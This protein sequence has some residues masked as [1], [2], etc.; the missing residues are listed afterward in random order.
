MSGT[1]QDHR[2]S[3][4]QAADPD[5]SQIHATVRMLNLAVAQIS[6]ALRDGEDSC[7]ALAGHFTAAVAGVARIGELAAGNVPDSREQGEIVAAC[8]D[9]QQRMQHVIVMFQF[10]DRLSQRLDHVRAGLA[11]LAT[12]VGDPA[13]SCKPQEWSSL[14]Q[15]MRGRY[16][17]P[18]EQRMF[19]ALL[20]G[21]SVGEA[22]DAVPRCA[23]QG[24]ASDIELF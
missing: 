15:A 7:A 4:A 2:P 8:G 3:N 9:V 20:A 13:R 19:A 21:A 22:L 14:Q 23:H 6:L 12:L 11:Q 18:E 10:Y 17:M 24:D 1:A 5:S 16:S